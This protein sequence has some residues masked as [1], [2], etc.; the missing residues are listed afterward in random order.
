MGEKKVEKSELERSSKKRAAISGIICVAVALLIYFL[1]VP[2]GVDS[3]GMHML[4]IFVG[5]ILALILQPLPTAAVAIIGLTASML[6][7]SMSASKEAFVGLGSS[8]VWLIVAAFFIAQGFVSTGLGRRIALCFLERLGGSSLGTSYGL[9]V[10]DLVLA[11]A[12]PS[13]TARLGGVLFPIITSISDLQHS[14]PEGGDE[15]RKR[16]GAFLAATANN[17]KAV[18]SAMFLTAMAGGPIIADL[19]EQQ[20]IT[21]SWGQWAIAGIVPGLVA[22][23]LI[24]RVVY[25]IFPPTLKQ[26][27]AA[28][29]DARTKRREMGSMSA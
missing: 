25:A 8:S 20:G 6:T 26:T 4:G 12:M 15:S 7:G 17:I 22:L 28:K 24:P 29:E 23:L 18:T 2:E 13:N 5:T 9:A 14:T 10:T 16:I 11:P 21:I 3:R 27:P 1:P 19:A